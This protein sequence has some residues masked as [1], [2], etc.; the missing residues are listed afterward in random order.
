M[1]NDLG[2]EEMEEPSDNNICRGLQDWAYLD[3]D[4]DDT[5]TDG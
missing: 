1:R 4:E 5:C 3:I 2:L